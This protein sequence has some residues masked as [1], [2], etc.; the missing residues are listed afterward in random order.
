M[1]VMGDID[2]MFHQVRVPEYDQDC[3][4][5][6]WWPDGNLDDNPAVFRMVVHLFGAVSSPTCCNL[7]LQKTAEINR[8]EFGNEVS[9]VIL[10]NFY[11]DDL[12]KS[13][14]SEA[15]AVTLVQDVSELCLKGGFRLRKWISNNRNVM[16]SVPDEDL[17]KDLCFDTLPVERALGVC[18]NMENDTFGFN[19]A[20]R[21]SLPTRRNLLSI[22]CS[23]YDPLG[24]AAPFVLLAKILLQ[25]L[26]LRQVDWD[27]K[28]SGADI[29]SWQQW[30][31]DLPKLENMSIPRCVQKP[32]FGDVESTQLHLF[33]DASDVGY[34]VVAY[35][36]FTNQDGAIHCSLLYSRARV[37]PLKKMTT[38][39]LELTAATLAVRTD[40]KLRQELDIDIDSTY[41]WTD[42]MAVIRYIANK[43]TRFHTFVANRLAVIHECS[44][45]KHLILLI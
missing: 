18:W 22:V 3:L 29:R 25:D 41:F 8:S 36:C 31:T 16:K 43:K 13:V 40:T 32:D 45:L 24:L 15:R 10:H 38:P 20:V 4:R 28:L 30:L 14:D 37:A 12:L 42:S 1:G 7:A 9:D 21:D 33:S 5:F 2:A 23:V 34:G 11:V 27:T 19:V 35:L 17:R 26:C 6:Y 44:D 39:R